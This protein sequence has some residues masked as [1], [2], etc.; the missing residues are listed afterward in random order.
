[1]APALSALLT[2][3]FASAAFN[4]IVDEIQPS[5]KLFQLSGCDIST[6][7][8]DLPPNQSQLVLPT[9]AT[10]SFIG[11]AFGVQNYTCT[12]SNNFTN[13]GAVAEL[14]DVS[15][16]V[17]APSFSTIQNSL[18]DVWSIVPYHIQDIINMMHLINPP[19][20]LAQHYFVPN[21][22]TGQ[23]VSPKWDFRSSGAFEGV[24]D[25][26]IIAKGKGTLP[27][28]TNS[29]RDVNWLDVVNVEG[30]I[31]SEVFRIDTVGHQPPAT[32]TFGSTP[33]LS[34]PYVSKYVFYGGSLYHAGAH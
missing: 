15:C 7:V 8:P 24:Q 17:S 4:A 18:Y 33:N 3:L 30:D 19:E 25:A 34:V 21:P 5:D 14:I 9:N 31:A 12:Q 1:M 27:A 20:I 10:P 2:S 26:F 11:L 29:T 28:P 16:I 32:C 13:V 22:V 6:F 23:G